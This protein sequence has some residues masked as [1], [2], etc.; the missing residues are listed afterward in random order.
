MANSLDAVWSVVTLLGGTFVLRP[1]VVGFLAFFLAAG[2]RDLGRA[3]TL[4]FLLWGFLVA[5]VAELS[6]T[7]GGA[8]LR[9]LPLHGGDRGA[10]LYLSNVPFFDPLSFTF[11][12][13]ASLLPRP[14]GARAG[15]GRSR[16][17]RLRL[18]ALA[19]VLMMWLDVVIDPLAVRGDRWFLGRIFYY[20]EPGLYFGV[21]AV[22]LRR[23]GPRRLGDG[24]RL[25]SGWRRDAAAGLAPPGDRR[26]TTWSWPSTWR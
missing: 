2:I 12:A 20:P 7:R 22:Q 24:R 17:G 6:S 1:Y 19:G 9:P 26:S 21:P 10:E 13:Y 16:A 3:R 25:S 4:G 23:L 18:V 8:A 5:L 11:L 15:L 14:A